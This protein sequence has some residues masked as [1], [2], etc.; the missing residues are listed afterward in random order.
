MSGVKGN[1]LFEPR[2]WCVLWLA[3]AQ[4]LTV[5]NL[6]V[7]GMLWEGGVCCA[8]PQQPGVTPRI[9]ATL[10]TCWWDLLLQQ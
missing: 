10:H 7:Q 3:Y 9:T 2:T 1:F 4:Q 8:W 5:S 6:A